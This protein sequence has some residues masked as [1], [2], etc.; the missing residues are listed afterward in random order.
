MFRYRVSRFSD[1]SEKI[2][3]FFKKYPI[4]GIKSKDFLDFCTVI[5][6]MKNKKHLCPEGIEEIRKIKAGTNSGRDKS[7]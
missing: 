5:E 1:L 3:A 4:F 7:N 2:I 6:L